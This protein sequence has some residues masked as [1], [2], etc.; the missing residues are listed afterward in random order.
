MCYT[1]CQFSERYIDPMEKFLEGLRTCLYKGTIEAHLLPPLGEVPRSGKG[2]DV[3]WLRAV[4]IT[5]QPGTPPQ[6]RFARQLPHRGAKFLGP[7]GQ[8][9]GKCYGI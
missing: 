6:S 4:H 2:G 5:T 9:K 7:P 3:G 8:L 1:E